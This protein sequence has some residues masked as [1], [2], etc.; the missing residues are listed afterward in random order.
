MS[1]PTKAANAPKITDRMII[2]GT[3]LTSRDAVV[4]GAI[5]NAKTSSDPTVSNEFTTVRAVIA[6]KAK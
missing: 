3:L 1:S 5:K 4:G 2:R 6:S